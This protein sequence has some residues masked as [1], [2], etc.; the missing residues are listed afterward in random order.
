MK[1]LFLLLL[2]GCASVPQK[3]KEDPEF[4][5]RGYVAC[6]QQAGEYYSRSQASPSEIAEAAQSGCEATF[7]VYNQIAFDRFMEDYHTSA[8]RIA[9]ARAAHAIIE[10]NI[11]DAKRGVIELVVRKRMPK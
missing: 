8:G 6:M 10:K 5:R 2:A 9:G 4:Y 11:Q 3:E 1:Y 7:N